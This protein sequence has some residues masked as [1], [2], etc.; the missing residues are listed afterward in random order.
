MEPLTG[1]FCSCVFASCITVPEATR[2]NNFWYV[3]L[4]AD[5]VRTYKLSLQEMSVEASDI[6]NQ[7][8]VSND[9]FLVV[10]NTTCEQ[11]EMVNLIVLVDDAQENLWDQKGLEY[12]AAGKGLMM[13]RMWCLLR[14][15]LLRIMESFDKEHLETTT[16][17]INS[18]L[19][20][21][22]FSLFH[23]R[24][25]TLSWNPPTILLWDNIF[26][27][28]FL[29]RIRWTI[30]RGSKTWHLES[31]AM[32]YLKTTF[33]ANSSTNLC[34]EMQPTGWR[35]CHQDLLLLGMTT[36]TRFWTTSLMMRGLGI[37]QVRSLCF[38]RGLL[39]HKTFWVRFRSYQM[40]HT[41]GLHRY[42][43]WVSSTEASIG[44][45]K[46]LWTLRV[47]EKSKLEA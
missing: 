6:T 13:Q 21:L 35:S 47:K 7:N 20:Y 15:S 45:I 37:L 25:T 31:S 18:M 43:Y 41:M 17:L 26:F 9:I 44:S 34:L 33:S 46:W 12:N 23:S 4:G 22:W 16:C 40:D 14:L 42:I 28:V 11:E 5:W 3:Q 38:L 30:L 39:R 36:R 2:K 1:T 8:Q 29:M 32:E 27:M 24:G 19:T 10:I